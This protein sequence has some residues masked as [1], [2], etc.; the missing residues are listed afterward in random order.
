RT[1]GSGGVSPTGRAV[2]GIQQIGEEF[3]E[4]C[5]RRALI[6]RGQRHRLGRVE[7]D[8]GSAVMRPG[9]AHTPAL[10]RVTRAGGVIRVFL[11]TGLGPSAAAHLGAP[12]LL[13]GP[14][15]AAYWPLST[16]D[17]AFRTAFPTLLTAGRRP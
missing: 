17:L 4:R 3:G 1:P 5:D 7:F 9:W 13:P 2:T 15:S 8:R 10:L 16:L 11:P 12:Q 6:V 14:E